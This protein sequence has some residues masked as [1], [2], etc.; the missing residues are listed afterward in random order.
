MESTSKAIHDDFGLSEDQNQIQQ[1][2]KV[3]ERLK[4]Q[5]SY[6]YWVQNNREQFPQHSDKSL[7]QPKKIDDPDLLK[8]LNSHTQLSNT[9]SAWNKAGTWEDKKLKMDVLKDQFSRHLVSTQWSSMDGQIQAIEIETLSGEGSIITSRGKRRIGYELEIKIKFAGQD[10]YEGLECAVHL[11]DFCD[12]GS[13]PDTNLYV[14]KENGGK[15]QGLK[16]KKD[17]SAKKAEKEIVAKCRDI[18]AFIRDEA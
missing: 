12:D 10:K 2:G 18:L 16:F 13:D 8:Q 17:Y 3:D 11:V 9:G 4:K 14:T 15:D 5:S 6:T 7:I 1:D